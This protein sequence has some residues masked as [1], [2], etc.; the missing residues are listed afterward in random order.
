MS[1]AL[2]SQPLTRCSLRRSVEIPL[3]GGT[4]TFMTFHGLPDDREHLAVGFRN[5]RDRPS[6]LVRIHSECL[7]GD[8][9]ASARCDCGGQL[10]EAIE[11]FSREGGLL[12]YLRQE[13]RGIGLYNKL[14]AYAL[15]RQGADTFRANELLGF[16]ADPR[17]YE[18]AAAILAALGVESVNLLTN[19]PEKKLQLESH[20]IKVAACRP[21]LVH[22]NH[23]NRSYLEAKARSGHWLPS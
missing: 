1:D 17:R 2:T 20:G 4:G 3:R 6:P 5:W 19:N 23:H 18:S 22:L 16:P 14:D 13:G 12:I 7:T 15:Q 11:L 21:T 8:A 10:E 9:F